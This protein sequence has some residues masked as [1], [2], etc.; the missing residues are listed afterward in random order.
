M[1]LLNG[2]TG[3]Q[4]FRPRYIYSIG[5]SSACTSMSV[6]PNSKDSVAAHINNVEFASIPSD[7]DKESTPE[8][9]PW[10]AAETK[11]NPLRRSFLKL[12]GCLFVAY[13]CSATNGVDANTFG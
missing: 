12:Y 11:V 10:R 2:N 6:M 9:R 8:V 1:P 3:S 13:L 4:A 5:P 7:E